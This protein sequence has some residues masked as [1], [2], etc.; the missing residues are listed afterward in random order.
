MYSVIGQQ[1]PGRFL[2]TANRADDPTADGFI[3]DQEA[4]ELFGPQKIVSI[5]ARGYWE[6][7]TGDSKAVLAE[8]VCLGLP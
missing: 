8:A 6:E 3:L 1:G 2:L 5:L 7:F 4:Q